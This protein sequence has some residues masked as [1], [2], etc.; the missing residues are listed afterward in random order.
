MFSVKSVNQSKYNTAD[1]IRGGLQLQATSRVTAPTQTTD[2][3]EI[4][5]IQR[6]RVG[7]PGSYRRETCGEEK[8]GEHAEGHAG[9][10][11]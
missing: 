11:A 6:S 7:N 1:A 5:R 2:D 3:G 8:Q 9:S 4:F 10:G